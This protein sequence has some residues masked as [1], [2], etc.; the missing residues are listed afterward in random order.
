MK[1]GITIPDY[2]LSEELLSAISHGFGAA[3]GIVALI[4][5]LL[6]STTTKEIV[7]SAI[8]CC[9][10]IILYMM[11]TMYHALK[12]N[13]AKKVFR[14]IDHCS[15]YLL[16]AGTYT[17]Y[18]LLGL[19]GAVGWILFGV[20]WGAAALG[21]ALNAVSISKFK[22]FSM[23]SYIAAGWVIIIAFKPLLDSIHFNGIILLL[24]GGVAYTLGAVL[25]G[26]GKKVK[27][28]HS[29]FHFFVLL[30]SILHFFSIYLYIL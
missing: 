4:L 27:Y 10:I 28:I 1:K 24:A 30:G 22:I 12:R 17:P 3:L 15:I 20:V 9:S 19:K 5:C 14:V 7:C 21:I 2:S 13:K 18:T 26:V 6:K 16:I 23:I 8:Y 29:V 25:Y 11:S